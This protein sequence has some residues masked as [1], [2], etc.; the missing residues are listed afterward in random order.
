MN[1]ITPK[2]L[3]SKVLLCLLCLALFPALI[4]SQ[5]VI[6]RNPEKEATEPDDA[7]KPKADKDVAPAVDPKLLK[8][9]REAFDYLNAHRVKGKQKPL[10]WNEE[11]AS[12]ARKHSKEMATENFFS[13][14]G[15]NGET[16]DEQIKEIGI[17]RFTNLG[18]LIGANAGQ[19]NPVETTIDRW[20]SSKE[21]RQYLFDNPW[22]ETGIGIFIGEDGMFYLT[23]DFLSK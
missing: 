12:L 20:I 9:E 10:I 17:T 16:I 3:I 21:R 2:F 6:T 13:V 14:K 4:Y 8:M 23:Q 7:E 19:E 18:R 1:K 15:A 22:S 11:L 5:T